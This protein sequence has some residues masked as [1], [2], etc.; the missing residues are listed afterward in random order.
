M[1][2]QYEII[3]LL[4]ILTKKDLANLKQDITWTKHQEKHERPIEVQEWIQNSSKNLDL[5]INN[6]SEDKNSVAKRIW[7][8]MKRLNS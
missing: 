3:K 2:N 6:A 7:K 5:T 1:M 4:E 8:A